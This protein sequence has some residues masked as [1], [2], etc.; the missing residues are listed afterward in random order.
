MNINKGLPDKFKSSAAELLLDALEEKF[1]P[2]LG[3]KKKAKFMEVKLLY[4]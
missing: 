4:P 3:D 2:I 1:I